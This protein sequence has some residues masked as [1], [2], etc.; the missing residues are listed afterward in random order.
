M[1]LYTL[2]LCS[3]MNCLF[4]NRV[5]SC[6]I[7]FNFIWRFPFPLLVQGKTPSKREGGDHELLDGN[8][9]LCRCASP[10]VQCLEPRTVQ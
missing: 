9:Q 7:Y 8:A 4:G 5:S 1:C 6:V 2:V 3:A 10:K